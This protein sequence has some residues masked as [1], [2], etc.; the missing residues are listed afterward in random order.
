MPRP[1]TMHYLHY[2]AC[3]FLTLYRTS[4][5]SWIIFAP[6]VPSLAPKFIAAHNKSSTSLIV[7]WSQLPGECFQG[8]PIGYNITYYPVDFKSDKLFVTANY[9]L[10][11]TVLSNL[12]VLTM[13]VINGS[14]I[15]SR[16][17]GPANT[18]KARTGAE[19]K[20]LILFTIPK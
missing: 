9:I 18:M 20:K 3:I 19:G 15:S 8:E 1:W 2:K 12:T 14:A 17:I 7:K 11:S 4:F 5:L 13:Y 10:N 16:G 6:L